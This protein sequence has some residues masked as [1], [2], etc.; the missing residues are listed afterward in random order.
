MTMREVSAAAIARCVAALYRQAASA[1]PQDV[2]AALGAAQVTEESPLGREVLCQIVENA[3]IAARDGVPIC[4]D[5]GMAVVFLSIGQDVHI[6]GG[7][8]RDAVNEGVRV[9]VRE[10]GLRASVLSPLLR[11]NTGDN[12]PAVLH[13]DIVPG[14]GVDITVAPKGFG[15]ENMSRLF[16]LNPS[17]GA[18]GAMDAIVRA[19]REAGGN[20]CP[21]VVVGVGV[22]GTA[23]TAMLTAKKSLLRTLGE[24]SP[25]ERVA[26]MERTCLER[27]NK[28]GIGPMGLGGRVTALAVHI[29][30][31]PTHIAGLPLAVNMQCHCARH[32]HTRI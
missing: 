16:M 4:Q 21:P 5:T 11:V 26:L 18:E 20:P 9:A 28:L 32:A 23:E 25:D 29:D 8:L 22:G 17:D 6:T 12:T 15:S 10:G 14:D 7:D 27:I 30:E 19:V 3:D 31:V 2:R 13:I 1:L 24:P